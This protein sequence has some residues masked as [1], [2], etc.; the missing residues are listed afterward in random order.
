[1]PDP[2]PDAGTSLDRVDALTSD[3]VPAGTRFRWLK[4]ALLR[5]LRVHTRRQAEFDR[6]ILLALRSL[7]SSG[8]AFDEEVG[9]FRAEVGQLRAEVMRADAALIQ[10]RDRHKEQ[11][12]RL[13]WL[14]S[15]TE[16]FR[17]ELFYEVRFRLEEQERKVR[18]EIRDPAAFA[19]KVAKFTDGL[20]VNL[21]AG[22][23]E[24]ADYL[25]V[26]R[27]DLDNVDIRADVRDLPFED[28]QLAE[29]YLAHLI[30]HF[31]EAEMRGRILPYWRRLLRPGGKLVVTCP[32]A[33]AMM[34]KWAAAEFDFEAL[35]EV[36]FGTQEYEGN[37]HH[38]M[39]T[40]ESL[41]SLLTSVGFSQATCTA[42]G[43]PNG[44]CLELE[45][46]ALK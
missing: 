22:S 2:A 16:N 18:P 15:W 38:N 34:K 39:F 11:A 40:P 1:M 37:S 45:V 44:L 21:G 28:G 19:A 17:K 32:D 5:V 43:R 8:A 35:R 41:I 3:T 9:R 42:R 13:D 23:L 7:M 20:R 29:I 31:P 36:T 30:E 33:E 26:D 12:D 14:I 24:R 25:N 46:E 10:V 4:R 6:S 27:R